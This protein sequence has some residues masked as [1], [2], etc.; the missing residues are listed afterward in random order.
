MAPLRVDLPDGRVDA[1][2]ERAVLGARV[3]ESVVRH[4]LERPTLAVVLQHVEEAVDAHRA[5]SERV[6]RGSERC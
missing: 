5:G 2:P 4:A 1:E 6:R 3:G